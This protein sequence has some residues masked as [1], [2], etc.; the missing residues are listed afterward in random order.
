VRI[1]IGCLVVLAGVRADAS[2]TCKHCTLDV[3]R[4]R[5]GN[6]PLLVVLHG[7]REHAPAAAARWRDAAKVRGWAVLALECPTDQGCKDSWWRW[8]GD[9][10]W[11][12]EQVAAVAKTAP[13]DPSRIYL[14]GWSGGATY[15]GMHA[16]TWSPGF[17][18]LVFHG[19][20][21]SPGGDCPAQPLPAYFLVGDRNPLHSLVQD[22]RTWFDDCKQ[23]FVWDLVSGG[24]HDKE[25]RALDRK[26]ALAI[27]DWLAAHRRTIPPSAK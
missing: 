20:G 25:D 11:L 18:A 22:L 27:L 9:P 24:D 12:V 5:D 2:P 1:A 3:P 13:I 21:H 23:Q 15:L 6:V 16:Q 8:N 19:G 10:R 26:K 4:S 14:A 17:A 7:D